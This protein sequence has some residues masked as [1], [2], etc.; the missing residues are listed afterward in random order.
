[1]ERTCK[2]CGETKPIEEF[3]KNKECRF[4]R[5]YVCK[6]C[7]NKMSNISRSKDPEY[8]TKVKIWSKKHY[9]ENDKKRLSEY[10]K[11]YRQTNKEK[12]SARRRKYRLNNIDKIRERERYLAR[13]RP[14]TEHRRLLHR[15]AAREYR[16]NHLELIKLRSKNCDYKE[17]KLMYNSYMLHILTNIVGVNLSKNELKQYPELIEL[18]RAQLKLKRLTKKEK[19]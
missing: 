2:K 18:K 6:C 5:S 11:I 13:N 10:Q 1:M 3:A 9:T 17:R 4:G 16:K 7:R 15:D 8:H 14:K 12:I 19:V